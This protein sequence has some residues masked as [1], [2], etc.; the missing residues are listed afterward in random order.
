M[1]GGVC[2]EVVGEV[3][4]VA[5]TSTYYVQLYD[6]KVLCIPGYEGMKQL[7]KRRPRKGSS[8]ALACNPLKL[9]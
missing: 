4:G 8:T 2:C 1:A 7:M 6:V 5:N 3:V 9:F